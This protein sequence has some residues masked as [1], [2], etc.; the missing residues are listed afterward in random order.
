M[1][2]QEKIIVVFR[3]RF[4]IHYNILMNLAILW[5]VLWI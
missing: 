1:V 3:H 2:A 4:S 5:N